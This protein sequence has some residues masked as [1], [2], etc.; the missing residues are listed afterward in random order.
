MPQTHE[1]DHYRMINSSACIPFPSTNVKLLVVILS[2][3]FV[4]LDETREMVNM[5]LIY[6][7]ISRQ[8]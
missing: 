4:R 1:W 7:S 5:L 3:R 6:Q 2:C 8:T